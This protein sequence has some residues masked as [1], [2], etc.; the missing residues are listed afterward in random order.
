[1]STYEV[2]LFWLIYL[3][4]GNSSAQQNFIYVLPTT[5][6][7]FETES[8]LCLSRSC[9]TLSDLI[10]SGNLESNTT[11]VLL[12][13]THTIAENTSQLALNVENIQNLSIIGRK[14]TEHVIPKIVCLHQGIFQISLQNITGLLISNFEIIGCS[15]QKHVYARTWYSSTSLEIVRSSNITINGVSVY[16]GKGVGLLLCDVYN[17]AI[18]IRSEFASNGANFVLRFGILQSSSYANYKIIDSIFRFGKGTVNHFPGG[19]HVEVTDVLM[20]FELHLIEV[21]LQENNADLSMI[22]FSIYNNNIIMTMQRV[23]ILNSMSPYRYT[24]FDTLNF[25]GNIS[26]NISECLLF[27]IRV[28]VYGVHADMHLKNVTF[29]TKHKSHFLY[30]RLPAVFHFNNVKNCMIENVKIVNS[31]IPILKLVNSNITLLGECSFEQNMNGIIVQDESNLFFGPNSV[32]NIKENDCSFNCSTFEVVDSTIV[33]QKNSRLLF[34]NNTRSF[35]G[36][37]TLYRSTI[38]VL[39]NVSMLFDGNFAT[40]G[41]AISFNAGSQI[42]FCDV[43]K[44]NKRLAEIISVLHK[45]F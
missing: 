41:G 4:I 17:D 12:P 37:L 32:T 40:N 21:T 44:T 24:S 29:S 18:I 45:Q 28:R 10:L 1:M 3:V 38:N 2:F 8:Q 42:Y 27:R 14:T 7:E 35:P 33:F 26:I 16:H 23:R 34:K 20:K 9:F 11:L 6:N 25:V 15:G 31:T 36:S 5:S 43:Q 19:L 22:L 30:K 13:G 39:N